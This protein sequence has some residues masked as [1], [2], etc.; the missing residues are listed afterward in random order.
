MWVGVAIY[1]PVRNLRRV[2]GVWIAARGVNV[3]A[4]PRRRGGVTRRRHLR[5]SA[6]DVHARVVL[7]FVVPNGCIGLEG[8]A[9][10]GGFH[11]LR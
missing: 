10:M 1:A 8:L 4:E 11:R 3:S 9:L 5:E 2:W 6:N 7:G